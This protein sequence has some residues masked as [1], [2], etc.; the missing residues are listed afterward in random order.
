MRIDRMLSIVVILL[1]RRKITARELA[2]RFE[3]SLRTIYRDIESINLSGIPVISNQGMDGGYEIPENYKLSRQY[4]SLSDLR[5]ILTALK[6]INAALDDKEIELIFEKI[7]C[8]LPDNEKTGSKNDREI[9]VF[10]T[11]GWGKQ[12]KSAGRIQILY[13]AIKNH[14]LVDILYRD[15]NG[16][17]S[18][19]VV[20]PMT[21]IQKGFSWYLFGFCRER[22]ALRLFKLTRMKHVTEL[23]GRFERRPGHYREIKTEWPPSEK[24]LEAVLKF[25][26][27]LKHKVEDY[28]EDS[29][30]I[31]EDEDSITVKTFLPN[32]E[33]LMAT[34][35]AYGP[36]V[37]VL[38]PESL[39]KQIRDRIDQMAFLYEKK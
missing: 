33:W 12:E 24:K 28:H 38:S 36:D 11:F 4:L 31:A 18:Q 25:S 22:N 17:S 20:E 30:I 5:S 15:G 19:R 3:V 21:L 9:L 10:D 27:G 29:D 6:G 2:D 26:A 1:N 34:I 13:E 32:G 14:R 39:R 23:P 8:L 37:E 16:Q 7:Q 35:L